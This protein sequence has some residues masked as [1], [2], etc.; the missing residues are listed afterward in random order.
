MSSSNEYLHSRV[1]KSE[2]PLVWKKMSR[3]KFSNCCHPFP[4]FLE[5]C[6]ASNSDFSTRMWRH[7]LDTAG[8]TIWAHDPH[9]I[10]D[11]AIWPRV[12]P[13]YIHPTW[14]KSKR[15]RRPTNISTT[16]LKN[17]PLPLCGQNYEAPKSQFV[18]EL[19]DG[20]EPCVRFQFPIFQRGC[21][22][23]P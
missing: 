3:V 22:D 9:G 20:R 2:I 6:E 11:I 13:L 18:A 14:A 23:I 5:R 8:V 7:W 17:P 12:D 15:G 16:A 4:G 19:C 10:V 1:E 21:G